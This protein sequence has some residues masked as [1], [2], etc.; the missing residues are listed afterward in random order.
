M[1]PVV[2][3]S[4]GIEKGRAFR[5]FDVT[6][7]IAASHLHHAFPSHMISVVNIPEGIKNKRGFRRV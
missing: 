7:L 1:M 5:R 3:S 2:D 6:L 4:E